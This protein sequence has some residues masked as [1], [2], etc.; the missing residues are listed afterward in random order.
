MKISK[1]IVAIKTSNR[2]YKSIDFLIILMKELV[3]KII[4]IEK[5]IELIK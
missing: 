4:T 1:K 3:G 2:L 5:I